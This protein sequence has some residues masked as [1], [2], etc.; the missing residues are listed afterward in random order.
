MGTPMLFCLFSQASTFSQCNELKNCSNYIN[1]DLP[2]RKK[3]L[4]RL[5]ECLLENYSES[6][7]KLIP[8]QVAN[9][10]FAIRYQYFP[11]ELISV[12]KDITEMDIQMNL[13][14]KDDCLRWNNQ[15]IDFPFILLGMQETWRP[16]VFVS[17]IFTPLSSQVDTQ[18]IVHSNGEC[19]ESLYFKVKLICEDFPFYFPNDYQICQMNFRF[20]LITNFTLSPFNNLEKKCITK[21][22]ELEEWYIDC[23]EFVNFENVINTQEHWPFLS[24]VNNIYLGNITGKFKLKRFPHYSYSTIVLPPIV[25]CA[26]SQI[27]TLMRPFID[28]HATILSSLFLSLAFILNN[29]PSFN[30][31]SLLSLLINWIY[32][33][34]SSNLIISITCNTIATRKKKCLPLLQ[35]FYPNICKFNAKPIPLFVI[36]SL[37]ITLPIIGTLLFKGFRGFVLGIIFMIIIW[38][39]ISFYRI[40]AGIDKTPKGNSTPMT[41]LK[42]NENKSQLIKLTKAIDLLTLAVQQLPVTQQHLNLP[43]ALSLRAITG[44]AKSESSDIHNNPKPCIE[45][46]NIKQAEGNYINQQH[47]L[48]KGQTD[49]KILHNKEITKEPINISDWNSKLALCIWRILNCI[50]ILGNIFLNIT[51]WIVYYRFWEPSF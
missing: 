4:N 46:Q 17:S 34:C 50:Q 45:E 26:C 27:I 37:T 13:F 21:H 7:Y 6:E 28:K 32:C 39:V 11:K 30:K 48:N 47:S 9:E 10:T 40:F 3:M 25:V 1:K 42:D 36:L 5:K 38:L 14:W 18:I 23:D 49:F 16:E 51:L 24:S 8:P 44:V 41:N 22:L 43:E 35:Q 19:E 33:L 29:L 31:F 15:E 20:K 2:N 12:E